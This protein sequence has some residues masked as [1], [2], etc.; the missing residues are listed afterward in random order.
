MHTIGVIVNN[1]KSLKR[2]IVMTY[3]LK[4]ETNE[5]LG[6]YFIYNNI[7]RSNFFLLFFF[8]VRNQLFYIIDLNLLRF[9]NS[10]YYYNVSGHLRHSFKLH[11]LS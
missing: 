3:E 9:D 11:M 1:S 10:T 6:I 2:R 8:L 4:F 5:N 7:I